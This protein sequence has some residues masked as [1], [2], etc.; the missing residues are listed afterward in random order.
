MISDDDEEELVIDR[1][2]GKKTS[3]SSSALR[4]RKLPPPP[5]EFDEDNKEEG[6]TTVITP[7]PDN[8]AQNL[9]DCVRAIAK[10]VRAG[11]FRPKLS[12]VPFGQSQ[13]ML[14]EYKISLSDNSLLILSGKIDRLVP[15]PFASLRHRACG[16]KP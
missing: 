15:P 10:M 8:N 6:N 14:G 12:E 16:K 11:T 9:E 2:G 3:A 5:D 1:A 4:K 13:D 7:T